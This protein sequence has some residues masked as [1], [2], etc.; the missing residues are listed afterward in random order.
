MS[1]PSQQKKGLPR[2]KTLAGGQVGGRRSRFFDHSFYFQISLLLAVVV[3]Y[4]FSQT[5]NAS[6]LHAPY[7]RMRHGVLI[8]TSFTRALFLY[9]HR[10]IASGW[11]RYYVLQSVSIK[12]PNLT[13]HRKLRWSGLALGVAISIIGIATTIAM[14]RLRMQEGR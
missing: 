1:A 10:V 5:V 12:T 9:F 2:M 13:S 7:T 3:V 11:V 4:V 8:H 14:T 6:L